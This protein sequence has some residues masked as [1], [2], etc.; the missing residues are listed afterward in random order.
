MKRTHKKKWIAVCLVAAQLLATG[1]PAYAAESKAGSQIIAEKSSE[2]PGFSY[3]PK[4]VDYVAGRSTILWK[5]S[6]SK[7]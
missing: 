5:T 1:M 2:D 3:G 7:H 4:S 6:M